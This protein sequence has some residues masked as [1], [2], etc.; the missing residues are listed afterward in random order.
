MK[1]FIAI[2]LA[3]IGLLALTD[4]PLWLVIAVSLFVARQIS[5]YYL[6]MYL[7]AQSFKQMDAGPN[8]PADKN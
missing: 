3:A 1:Y 8:P 5:F 7:K 6:N 2:D 4:A